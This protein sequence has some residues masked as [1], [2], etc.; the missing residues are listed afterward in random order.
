[1]I[2]VNS[3]KALNSAEGTNR[4]LKF[5]V[6]ESL[7]WLSRLSDHLRLSRKLPG[8]RKRTQPGEDV[9]GW[10]LVFSAGEVV[11]AT[12]SPGLPRGLNGAPLSLAGYDEDVGGG[13]DWHR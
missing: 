10:D 6:P 9:P 5:S 11:E 3:G 12:E 1:M 13:W 8:R 7:G 2:R 4:Q